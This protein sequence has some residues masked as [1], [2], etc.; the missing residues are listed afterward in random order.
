[1]YIPLPLV[2]AAAVVLDLACGDARS[3]AYDSACRSWAHRGR[4]VGLRDDRLGD[5]S[6]TAGPGDREISVLHWNVQWGGGLF[7]VPRTW[8]AQRAAIVD[9]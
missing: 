5:R 9:Q 6:T 7:R 4:L 2:G 3:P 1:M 8:A